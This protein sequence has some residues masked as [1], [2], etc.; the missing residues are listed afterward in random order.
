MAMSYIWSFFLLSSL[1]CAVLTGRTQVLAAAAMQGAQQGVTL[2]LSL[3]GTL[4]LWSGVSRVMERCGLTE[5]AAQLFSPLLARLFPQTFRDREARGCLSAN[6]SAN[7]LGLGSA[8]TP[9]GVQ[10]VRRMQTLSAGPK[11]R[12]SN[13]MCRLI[14][15]NTA[16]FQLLPTTVAALRAGLGASRPFEILPAVWLSSFCSVAV[17]L[18]AAVCMEGR[19]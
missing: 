4:C 12:A 8:A 10:C 17:G 14:V 5:H 2:C 11:D 9:M 13:E 15:L 3:A 1:F 6:F 18:L 7:L 16:S 19:S